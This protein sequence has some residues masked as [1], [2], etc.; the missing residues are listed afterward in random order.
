MKTS[1]FLFVFIVTVCISTIQPVVA[2]SVDDWSTYMHDSSRSGYSSSQAPL[3]NR[4]LWDFTTGG[5]VKSS[6]VVANGIIY[7]G[8]DDGYVYALNAYSGAVEWSYNTYGPVEAAATVLNGVVYVGGFHSHAVFALNASTGELVWN[9]PIESAGPNIN[10]AT[11]VANGLVYVN[12]YVCSPD[13]GGAL[14]ALNAS[15]G[16]QVWTY[17]PSAWIWMAPAV[18]GGVVYIET[19]QGTVVALD[20]TSGDVF[21]SNPVDVTLDGSLS[22]ANGRVYVGT[23]NQMAYAL[24]AVSGKIVWGGSIIGGVSKSCPAIADGTLYLSSTVGGTEV[25]IEAGGVSALNATTG[26]MLWNTTIGSISESSPSVADG[27][28]FVGSD[29]S[30]SNSSGE[31]FPHNIY[32]LN[33]TTGAIIWSYG[34]GGA[35]YSSPATANDIVYVGSDDGK[36]YAFGTTQNILPSP[37]PSPSATFSPSPSLSPSPTI[38]EF[39]PLA[40]VLM[41]VAGLVAVALRKKRWTL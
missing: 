4:T 32:A 11:A 16:D 9:S 18:S 36:V 20:A 13:R 8:S 29:N 40:L 1:A 3:T 27:V 26:A 25:T 12:V 14:Y 34:T 30:V 41:G 38:P 31:P 21:W 24:D 5:A 15:T 39:T 6:P 19:L 22:V 23:V 33:A 35:V 37:T 10:S 2:S 17:K 7:V 28:V